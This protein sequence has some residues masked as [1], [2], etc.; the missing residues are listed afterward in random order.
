MTTFYVLNI[1]R[2]QPMHLPIAYVLYDFE[3]KYNIHTYIF[4]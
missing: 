3:R 1:A 2:I 4:I